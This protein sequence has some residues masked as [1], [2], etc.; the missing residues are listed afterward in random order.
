MTSS[1]VG[2]PEAF[3]YD[4]EDRR[5]PFVSPQRPAANSPRPAPVARAPGLAGLGAAEIT[6][7]GV[8]VSLDKTVAIIEGADRRA[9]VVA[10]GQKLADGQI[11]SIDTTSL[12]VRLNSR[13]EVRRSLQRSSSERAGERPGS[14][15]PGLERP[16]GAQ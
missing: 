16:S 10:A 5:D 6:L 15:E 2:L 8:I 11:R 14:E 13:G 3:V 4:A 7:R 12:V 9:Y 1:R